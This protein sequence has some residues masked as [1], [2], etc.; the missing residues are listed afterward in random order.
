MST[1][2]SNRNI[3]LYMQIEEDLKYKI[4][5]GEW[6]PGDRILSEEEY[7]NIY[8]VS[9]ITVRKALKNLELDGLLV[10]HSGKGTFVTNWVEDE[11]HQYTLVK[12]LTSEMREMGKK[13][14]TLEASVEIIKADKKLANLLSIPE[15]A[16]VFKLTRLRGLDGEVFA[17]SYNWV[18]FRNVFSTD[19]K[20][21]YESFYDYLKSHGIYFNHEKQFIE[22]GL[23]W[24][25]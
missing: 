4:L 1:I 25:Y 21:Y 5:N 17:F 24:S 12:G 11:Q 20:D 7:C 22:A 10:R 3:P 9:R 23:F 16:D 8:N 14:F 2:K 18:P 6:K 19:N 15:N 13:A